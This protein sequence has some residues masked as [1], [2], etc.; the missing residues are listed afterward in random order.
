MGDTFFYDNKIHL[1]D[2][3][4]GMKNLPNDSADIV[5]IDPPYNIKKNFGNNSDDMPM[6]EYVKWCGE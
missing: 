1:K 3:L 2:C 6:G 5:I 4:K